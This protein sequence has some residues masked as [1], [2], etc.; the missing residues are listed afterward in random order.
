[1]ATFW[2]IAAPSVYHLFFSYP[3]FVALVLV[4]G[5]LCHFLVVFY[6]ELNK[7]MP[8]IFSFLEQ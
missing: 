5:G 1:M 3:T 7:I 6:S 4:R 2:E 8:I